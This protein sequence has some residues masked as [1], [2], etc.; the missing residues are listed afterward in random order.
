MTRRSLKKPRDYS[1]MPLRTPI[2]GIST[3]DAGIVNGEVILSTE[4]SEEIGKTGVFIRERGS[5]DKLLVT[6]SPIEGEVKIEDVLQR[7]RTM[8][9]E[10]S[11][12]G[13]FLP[14]RF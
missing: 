12:T 1:S 2:G 14:F 8:K 11:A 3:Y 9:V 4:Y 5:Q 7:F 10:R 13:S 6:G